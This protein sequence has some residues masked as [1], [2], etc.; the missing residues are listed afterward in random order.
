MTYEV[1]LTK[2]RGVMLFAAVFCMAAL[3]FATGVLVGVG[4]WKPTMD[5]LALAKEYRQ[6]E[7]GAVK[8]AQVKI[9]TAAPPPAQDIPAPAEQSRPATAP[10][11]PEAATPAEHENTAP[12]VAPPPPAISPAVHEADAAEAGPSPFV[13]Q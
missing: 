13:L 6:R 2:G 8:R 10:A 12:P 3:L 11:I 4:L 5:E 1:S 7:A 9:P